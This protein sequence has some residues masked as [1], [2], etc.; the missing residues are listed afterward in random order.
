MQQRQGYPF[1]ALTGGCFISGDYSTAEPIIDLDIYMETLPP[2]GRLCVSAKAVRMLVT[3]MGWE[4]MSEETAEALV[5]SGHEIKR[6]ASENRALRSSLSHII[7]AAALC[8]LVEIAELASEF[9]AL[10][11]VMP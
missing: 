8:E 7:E 6:L 9:P 5:D 10:R 11:Q 2:F 1:D 4:L 3:A